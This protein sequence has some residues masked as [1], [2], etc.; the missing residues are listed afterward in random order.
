MTG[1]IDARLKQLGIVLPAAPAAAGGYVPWLRTGNLVFIAGQGPVVD[2]QMRY[3]GQVGRDLDVAG[4]QDAAR[5]VALNVLA[6]VRAALDGDLDR[7]RRC[8]RLAGHVAS[9]E[10]FYQ[11]PEVL[12]AASDLMVAVFGE[13]GR[14]TRLAVGANALPR[15]MT[16]EIEAVFEVT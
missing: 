3:T 10:G 13:A 8:V 7:V 9:A 16:V 5:I 12:N 1:Q 11:Q 2:G 14:H 6:Q 15:N 4:G